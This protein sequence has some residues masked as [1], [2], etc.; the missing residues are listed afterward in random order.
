MLGTQQQLLLANLTNQIIMNIFNKIVP[1]FIPTKDDQ[2]NWYRQELADNPREVQILL[3]E[4]SEISRE[5]SSL[6]GEFEA[7]L[8]S[9]YELYN[10]Y[11]KVKGLAQQTNFLWNRIETK[12]NREAEIKR[13]ISEF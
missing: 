12:Q 4:F 9:D 2:K 8:T 13:I 5:Y 3:K 7:R 1:W 10:L 6:L 11:L